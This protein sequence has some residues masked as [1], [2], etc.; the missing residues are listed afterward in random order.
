M[1]RIIGIFSQNK[2][3]FSFKGMVFCAFWICLVYSSPKVHP[4][5]NKEEKELIESEIRA[6]KAES[7][8]APPYRQIF[9]SIPFWSLVLTYVCSYW[10]FYTLLTNVPTYLNN[11][12]HIPLT[13]VRKVTFPAFPVLFQ[14]FLA[15]SG[16]STHSLGEG[17]GQK[18]YFIKSKLIEM[19]LFILLPSGFAKP[20]PG[21]ISL[22]RVFH[23]YF[24]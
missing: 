16:F 4:R 13:M 15:S 10:G 19:T 17:D 11:V 21:L 18:Q 14:I 8:P 3:N 24:S 9:T 23:A 20:L 6:N 2:H 7:I 22:F 12:Q 5:I 1:N